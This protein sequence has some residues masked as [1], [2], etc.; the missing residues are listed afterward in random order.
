MKFT[1]IFKLGLV[2]M[3]YAAAA[4]VGLAFVYAGTEKT[5]KARAQADLENALRELFPGADGFEDITGS[6]TS[7][8]SLVGFE[9]EYAVSR[10]G[11]LAGAALR[12]TGGSYGGPI[13][14]LVG[15][16][17]DGTISRVKIM[18]HSDTP[19]FGANAADPN[20][21]VDEARNITFTGQFDG[22]SLADPF[23]AKNDIVIVSG[24]TV[25]S[26]AVSVVVKTAGTAAEQWLAKQGAK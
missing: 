18:E 14:V 13:K 20:Y 2:L 22:K 24:A 17:A 5:I 10:G 19:G 4:C 21:F 15:V 1:E 12:A 11:V 7:P 3:I 6:I 23:E 9:S 8:D 16:N 26:R 25:T